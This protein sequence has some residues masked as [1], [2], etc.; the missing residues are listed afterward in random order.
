MTIFIINWK[1][2][3]HSKW[4]SWYATPWGNILEFSICS[5]IFWHGTF[6]PRIGA[7]CFY[8][9][10]SP[11]G[12]DFFPV[13]SR[14]RKI[15]C[16]QLVCSHFIS[17]FNYSFG[18][19]I[20]HF[21]PMGAVPLR[22][23]TGMNISMCFRKMGTSFSNFNKSMCNLLP[24]TKCSDTYAEQIL[25]SRKEGKN[26]MKFI[27]LTNKPQDEV[28]KTTA[29]YHKE[30][31]YELFEFWKNIHLYP[32]KTHCLN[33]NKEIHYDYSSIIT[34]CKMFTIPNSY[35]HIVGQQH[36]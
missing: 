7:S 14:A 8:P 27:A 13:T 1:A 36:K 31:K 32:N 20:V 26:Q 3:Y 28:P 15:I 5:I 33:S 18:S 21:N 12:S 16:N 19:I 22:F 11:G 30:S 34:L 24:R 6:T 10:L 4:C 2:I 9:T 17:F 25:W 29:P 35:V 23:R